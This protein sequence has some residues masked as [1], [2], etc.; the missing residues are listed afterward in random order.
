MQDNPFGSC[1]DN[2]RPALAVTA[3]VLSWAKLSRAPTHCLW[4]WCLWCLWFW[5]HGLRSLVYD[6]LRSK[7]T[8]CEFHVVD[9]ISLQRTIRKI[10]TLCPR[11]ILFF[12]LSCVS[13]YHCYC[14]CCCCCS[15]CC[16]CLWA[17]GGKGSN[18]RLQLGQLESNSSRFSSEFLAWQKDC[19]LRTVF[20]GG[21]WGYYGLRTNESALC[22]RR[23]RLSSVYPCSP[24]P[25]LPLCHHSLRSSNG[26]LL[27]CKIGKQVV[28]VPFIRLPPQCARPNIATPPHPQHRHQLH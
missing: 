22:A 18:W 9:F 2:S 21:G 17:F 23:V 15:S 26:N 27:N 28:F 1:H 5:G 19:K 16:C 12:S 25:P 14:F 3:C 13:A 6:G 10:C 4:L 8:A 24:F 20:S 11:K 7:G